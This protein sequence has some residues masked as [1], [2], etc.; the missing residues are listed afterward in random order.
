MAR[1]TLFH[2][3]RLHER[4]PVCHQ[5]MPQPLRFLH[6]R[7]SCTGTGCGSGP[8]PRL[9]RNTVPFRGRESSSGTTISPRIRSMRRNCF[10]R[11][12]HIAS[13]G[14]ARRLFRRPAMTN[15]WQRQPRVV[16]S[17]CSWAWNRYPSRAWMR[18]AK[19]STV[20]KTTRTRSAA[21]M[22]TALPSKRGLSLVLTTTHR[23]FSKILVI[24]LEETGVQNATFNILTPYPGTPL[25]RR[26]D[27]QGR[28]LTR[29][30]PRYNG[31]TDVVFQPRQMSA[32]ELLAGF[33]YANQ[34]FYSLSSVVKRLRASPIQLWWALPLNFAYMASLAKANWRSSPPVARV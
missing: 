18:C 22:R 27:A 5:G 1:K 9:R 19:D 7:H 34:R 11:L 15:F 29:D 16:A 17:S 32:E 26:L 24:F 3:R 14:A 23:R 13:G 10:V 28:I 21:S 6:H 31:R 33:R 25:F 8:L 30:W 12:R 2:R 4:R 20:L